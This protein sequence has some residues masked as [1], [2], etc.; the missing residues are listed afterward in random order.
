MGR[1]T[2][3]GLNDLQMEALAWLW[4][5]GKAT[6]HTLR[7]HGYRWSTMDA[8]VARGFAERT[9]QKNASHSIPIWRPL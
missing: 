5:I 2:P 8:L 4:R 3:V 1:S 6:P 9:H 7:Q